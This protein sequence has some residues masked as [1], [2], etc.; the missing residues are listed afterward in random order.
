MKFN[1]NKIFRTLDSLCLVGL[2]Y[3]AIMTFVKYG[4]MPEMIPMHQNFMGEIDRYGSKSE[5]FILVLV[6][7]GLHSIIGIVENYPQL[8][9]TGIKLTEENKERVYSLLRAMVKTVKYLVSAIF[10]T[11]ILFTLN[12]KVMPVYC[13]YIFM[14]LVAMT[15]IITITKLFRLK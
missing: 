7:F 1:D 15:I 5:I 3:A 9:N 14:A 10:I 8:W 6:A 2:F 4:D 12:L 13:L 11:M